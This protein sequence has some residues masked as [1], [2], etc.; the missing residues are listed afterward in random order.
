MKRKGV[1]CMRFKFEK[2]QVFTP[3]FLLKKYNE[4]VEQLLFLKSCR[5][6]G[7]ELSGGRGGVPPL[8]HEKST[9]EECTRV[10][11]SRAKR[12][13]REL[14]LMNN[15][16]FFFTLTI[17]PYSP[18]IKD[19]YDIEEVSKKIQQKF[20][21][22]YKKDDTLQF[23]YVF[24][25]HRDGAFH[26]HG[27]LTCKHENFYKNENGYLSIRFFDN[28]GFSSVSK[29]RNLEKSANY[30]TKYISKNI[31]KQKNGSY[32][33]RSRNLKNEPEVVEIDS[34]LA[35][36]FQNDIVFKNDF[37]KIYNKKAI[38]ILKKS[39]KI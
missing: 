35:S 38:D 2:G 32:Y 20:K 34:K 23:L 36:Q 18:L 17:S 25:Q 7:F 39:V 12:R 24:E 13:I 14:V 8:N 19:R 6:P 29:I 37:V 9:Q 31:F 15:F 16:E 4:N 26:L 1:F 5:R 28:I 30:S 10:A 11:L 27:F 3:R 33:F 21:N 22:F